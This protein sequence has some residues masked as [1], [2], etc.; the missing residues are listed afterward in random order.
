LYD[1]G[2]RF[3]DPQI[4]RWT[5]P[6]DLAELEPSLT[7]YRYCYNNPISNNDPDG[8][9]EMDA[10]GNYHTTDIND[11]RNYVAQAKSG[12]TGSSLIDFVEKSYKDQQAFDKNLKSGKYGTYIN[13]VT[14]VGE[15]KALSLNIEDTRS[16]YD[17]LFTKANAPGNNPYLWTPQEINS[18]LKVEI[19][20]TS[21]FVPVGE[22]LDVVGALGRIGY[23]SVTATKGLKSLGAAAKGFSKAGKVFKGGK[24]LMRDG[25]YLYS[26]GKDF[27]KWFHRVYEDA[28]A[29]NATK[30]E[31]DEAFEAWKSLGNP[32]VK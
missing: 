25:G 32:K 11:I 16:D 15:G 2:A 21:L 27:V 1:Y 30:A 10:N 13:E 29:P 6:D 14:K 3:Y 8:L 19:Q 24:K 26:K 17:Y 23:E 31:I 22:L 5:T 12:N 18:A 9:W 28:A 20:I 4:G 7:P